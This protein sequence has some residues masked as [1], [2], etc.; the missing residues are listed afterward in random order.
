MKT[1]T[2]YITDKSNKRY[3]VELTGAAFI[4]SSIRDL[5][6]HLQNAKLNPKLYHFLD[7]ETAKIEIE[8]K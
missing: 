6:R 1:S 7:L 3:F 4:E 5:K 8:T 2:V